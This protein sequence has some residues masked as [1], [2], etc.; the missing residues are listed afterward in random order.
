MDSFSKGFFFFLALLFSPSLFAAGGWSQVFIVNN[1]S[2]LDVTLFCK[3]GDVVRE[4]TVT[5]S[6]GRAEKFLWEVL[7]E[8]FDDLF[9][10][11]YAC[12]ISFG[13][14]QNHKFKVRLEDAQ[15]ITVW[16]I[17][18]NFGQTGKFRCGS[19]PFNDFSQPSQ[20][21][22]RLN[23]GE[24]YTGVECEPIDIGLKL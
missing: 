15:E 19:E 16:T 4:K 10:G 24:N 18:G 23:S 12:N 2:N 7:V 14:I 11:K 3:G 9:G 6:P 22:T 8:D 5:V 1:R 17:D 20:I 13:N 21:I